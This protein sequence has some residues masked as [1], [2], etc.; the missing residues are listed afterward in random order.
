LIMVN[1][2]LGTFI[3]NQPSISDIVKNTQGSSKF[4]SELVKMM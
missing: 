4:Y 2:I 3:V 1:T